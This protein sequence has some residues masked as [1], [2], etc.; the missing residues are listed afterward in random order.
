MTTIFSYA[1]DL[2]TINFFLLPSTSLPQGFA[3]DPSKSQP[4][5]HPP[6]LSKNNTH[7]FLCHS[8]MDSI[9]L[10]F[11]FTSSFM[12]ETSSYGTFELYANSIRS[13]QA[14]ATLLPLSY[15]SVYGNRTLG[16]Q[17]ENKSGLQ[18]T[19]ATLNIYDADLAQNYLV[20][21]NGNCWGN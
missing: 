19:G 18:C 3:S 2:L 9:A 11:N 6:T 17:C 8:P 15:Q 13:P 14:Q 4:W 20:C 7:I 10:N 12:W 21:P 5:Y 1:S 16:M